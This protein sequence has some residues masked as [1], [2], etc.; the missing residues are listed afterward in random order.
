MELK[1]KHTLIGEPF[2]KK[3]KKYMK[4][5]DYKLITEPKRV[6]FD[7]ENLFNGDPVL[8]RT[9]LSF[10]NEQWKDIYDEIKPQYEESFGLVFKE[11]ANRIFT[12]VPLNEIFLE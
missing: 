2:K 5:V 9:T 4:I 10:F 6:Y 7:F 8:G 12:K 3:G 1:T 11:I